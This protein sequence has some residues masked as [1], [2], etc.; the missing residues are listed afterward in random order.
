MG[1]FSEATAFWTGLPPPVAA[2]GSGENM[3]L[4]FPIGGVYAPRESEYSLAAEYGQT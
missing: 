4:A 2:D 1:C 3:S